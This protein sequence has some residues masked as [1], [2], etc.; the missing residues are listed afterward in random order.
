VLQGHE[1]EISSV[2][3]NWDSTLVGSASLDG[4]AKLWDARSTDC[5]ATVASHTDE[6][7]SQ[8]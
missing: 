4:S 8:S 5:L 2:Q 7:T 3:F 1:G 6:V